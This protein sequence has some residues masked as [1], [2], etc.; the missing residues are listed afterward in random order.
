MRM[1]E[2]ELK[3]GKVIRVLPGEVEVLRKAG[4]LKEENSSEQNKE[5]EGETETLSEIL[6][7]EP[8]AREPKRQKRSGYRLPILTKKERKQRKQWKRQRHRPLTWNRSR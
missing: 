3:D 6:V 4:K 8:E 7:K 5:P 2:V 1:V